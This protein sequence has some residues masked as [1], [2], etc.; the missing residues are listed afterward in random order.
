MWRIW[1]DHSLSIVILALG[2]LA[3]GIALMFESGKIFDSIIGI[4]HGLLTVGL[5]NILSGK[6]R[7]RNK[8]EL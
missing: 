2:T 5:I 4:G 1:R 7:E 6:L 8:P 3:I